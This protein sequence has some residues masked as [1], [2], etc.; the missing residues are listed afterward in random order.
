MS[1]HPIQFDV[2]GRTYRQDY[3]PSATALRL[4]HKLLKIGFGPLLE[5]LSRLDKGQGLA[6]LTAD[7]QLGGAILAAAYECLEKLTPEDVEQVLAWLEP[8]TWIE[9]AD[10][11]GRSQSIRLDARKGQVFRDARDMASLYTYVYRSVEAQL[12]PFFLELRTL[13]PSALSA[14]P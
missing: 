3:L 4:H 11:S 7:P 8:V 14:S 10:E 1:D 2:A 5:G 12:R 9:W 13:L 6:G